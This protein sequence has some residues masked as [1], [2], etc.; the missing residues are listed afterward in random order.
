MVSAALSLFSHSNVFYAMNTREINER[1][2]CSVEAICLF[3]LA[4]YS[5]GHRFQTGGK[6]MQFKSECFLKLFCLCENLFDFAGF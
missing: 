4:K 2:A 3:V 6:R 5:A 1:G